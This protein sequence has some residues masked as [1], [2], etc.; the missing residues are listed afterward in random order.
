MSV[1][2]ATVQGIMETNSGDL[3]WSGVREVLSEEV[4]FEPNPK[5]STGEPNRRGGKQAK[6]ITHT[7]LQK[8]R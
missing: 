1:I 8:Q 5:E 6:I 2:A 3:T 7:R 4:I